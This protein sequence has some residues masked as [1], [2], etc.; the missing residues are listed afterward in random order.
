VSSDLR[1]AIRID[2]AGNLEGRSRQ[3]TQTLD[4]FAQRG[5]RSLGTL[6]RSAAKLGRGLDRIGNRYTALLTGAAGAGAVRMLIGLEERFTML[7]I[8]ANISADQVDALKRQIYEVA[9]APQIRVDP[10][11]LTSAI[12]QIVEMT[13]DLQFAQQSAETLGLAIS[14]TGGKTGAAIGAMAAE[15][16]KLGMA[17]DQ[18][19]EAIDTLVTQ[20]K[21]GSFTLQNLAG[22]GSRVVTAYAAATKGARDGV[23]VLREMG[24]ALQVI[25]AG[26]GSAEQAATAFEQ[27]IGKLS[28]PNV[29]KILTANGIQ[30]FDPNQPG[31][32]VLRPINELLLEIMEKSKGKQSILRPLFGEQAVRAFAAVTPERL[33]QYMDVQAD[34]SQLLEDS[35]DHANTASAAL[36]NLYAAWQ[37]FAD[38]ELT[39]PIQ[40]LADMLNGLDAEQMQQY[41]QT[42]KTGVLALGGA[43]VASKVVRGVLALRRGLSGGAGGLGGALGGAVGATM[44]TPV[45]VVNMPGGGLPGAGG[46]PGGGGAGSRVRTPSRWQLLRSAPNMKTI[47]AMGAG[48]VGTAGLAAAG[49]GAAG[50]AAGSVLYNAIDETSFADAIGGT[51]ATILARF[52]NDTA[53]QALETDMAAKAGMRNELTIRIEGDGAGRARVQQMRGD[54]LDMEVESG[55]MMMGP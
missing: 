44:A 23:T 36:T 39:A 30:V 8:Q 15:M 31:A 10:G 20:G 32:E 47:G 49:A 41:F 22:L 37:R 29:T 54:N 7:G 42:A 48:A 19:R 3:Y 27:L 13:G 9:S 21:A 24:A 1:T 53:R 51:I 55:L 11:E 50:F 25:R 14:A 6:S 38:S 40:S 18:V 34:G 26:T 4:R 2:L 52:G 33:R 17:G 43:I 28:D 35:Q 16:Q 12:E 45:Y 46:L 5:R